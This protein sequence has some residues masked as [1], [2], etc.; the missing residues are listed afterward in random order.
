MYFRCADAL[1]SPD[2]DA[3]PSLACEEVFDD[4]SPCLSVGDFNS[5]DASVR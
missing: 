2:D 3:L 5:V 4:I 1:D